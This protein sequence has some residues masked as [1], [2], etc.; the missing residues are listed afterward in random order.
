MVLYDT[1][2]YTSCLELCS[3]YIHI[4]YPHVCCHQA[5]TCVMLSYSVTYYVTCSFEKSKEIMTSLH[6]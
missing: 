2:Y 3:P 5:L 6:S 1:I 4:F